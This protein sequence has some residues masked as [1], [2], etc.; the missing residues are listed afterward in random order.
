ML[1]IQ[2]CNKIMNFK[3]IYFRN[4]ILFELG[5]FS[6]VCI[7]VFAMSLS[8][9]YVLS[10]LCFVFLQRGRKCMYELFSTSTIISRLQTFYASDV[11][12]F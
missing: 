2:T 12:I 6:P 4:S 3:N 1:F 9:M 10:W 5:S 8:N 11:N 7:S